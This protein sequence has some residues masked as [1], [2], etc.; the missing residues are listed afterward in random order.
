MNSIKT[1]SLLLLTTFILYSCRKDKE[2]AIVYPLDDN[3]LPSGAITGVSVNSVSGNQL[4]FVLD[5]AVFRDSRNMEN[6]LNKSNF[7]DD[8]TRIS[9]VDY[10]FN[11]IN[12]ETK[13]GNS[14]EDYSALMLMDQSGSISSTDPGNYRLEAA[15]AFCR[16]L[17]KSDKVS[18]W[19][20]QGSSYKQY[21]TGFTQDTATLLAD[22]ESLRNKETGSTPLYY[23]QL[24]VVN[25]CA[26]NSNN[27]N[28][29]V[30]TFTDG[31]DNNSGG[32]N[33]LQVVNN[34][35]AKNVRLF[36]IGLDGAEAVILSR[37]ALATNG[38]YMFA[39]DAKQLISMFG[40]LG[41]LLNASATYYRTTW[42][43]KKASGNFSSGTLS[44]EITVTLPY[45]GTITIPFSVEY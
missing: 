8:T 27:N 23:A 14:K 34:A 24:N 36:N 11:I 9:G 29:A 18:L 45:G 43:V 10:Y 37:Q 42:R 13:S 25:Y 12:S 22:I 15:T 31:A 2:V 19:S 17:G 3:S 32:I 6:Q 38:A 16:A 20:F 1:A 30:L 41:K 21:G 33:S 4:E 5:I 26:A 7:Q 39:R 28:K 44:Y 35:L 40:N